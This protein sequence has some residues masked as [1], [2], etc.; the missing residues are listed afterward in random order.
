MS[1][2]IEVHTAAMPML[3]GGPAF[4]F[5]SLQGSEGLGQLFGYT[6][7][8]QTPDAPQLTAS[9]TANLPI[10]NLVGKEISIVIE[11]EGKGFM[12]GLGAGTRE[13]NGL[14]T[15]GRFI[16]NE[17][18]RG[19]Y[20][21]TV[22]PW[23]VL[24]TRT[25]DYK[26]FQNQTPLAIVQQVLADYSYL[27]ETRV[28][29]SY[30]ER[31]FQVQ[32]GE[33]DF[34]F[35]SR[36]MQE[37]G[38]YYYFEHRGGV[39][40]LILVDDAGT[41][42]P[43]PSAAYQTINFYGERA[44]LDEE[45][46]NHFLSSEGLQSGQWVTDDF[47][48]TKPRA[49]LQSLVKMPRHTG[50]NQQELYRW[51]GDYVDPD[52]GRALARTRMEEAGAPGSRASGSGNLR[53]I[54]PGC[55]FKLQKYPQDKANI[56]YLVIAA[57]LS[58][59]ESSHASG[60]VGYQCHT[61]F[62]LQPAANIYRS[63]QTVPKPLTTGPQTA[64]VTGPPGQEI[65][66]N[67]YGQIKVSFHWNRYCTKD[68]N[69]SCWIRVSNP[70]AGSNFG[71]IAI[72]RI[73]QEV[74]V[75]FEN[76]DPDRPIITGRVYNALNMPP[77]DLPGN[78][79]Q[80]GILTRS[81]LD[82][83]PGAG[84]KDG[85]GDAN[86]LRFEDKKGQEQLWLHAQK[87]QL[88]EVEHDEDKWVGNDR[89]K[90]I[91][92]DETNQIKR[93][94]TE[95]V[96]RNEKITVHGWRMEEVDGDET[97][98]IHSNRTERVDHHEKISIGDN[99][100]EEV[101]KDENIQVGKNRS[102]KVGSSHKIKVG[103]SQ[104]ETIG[105]M[106]TQTVGLMRMDN[107]GIA[108]NLNVGAAW[109]SNVGLT[110]L[111]NIGQNWT[112]S[113]GSTYQITAK[114]KY[115]CEVGAASV[116]MTADGDIDIQG[117][118]IRINGQELVEIIGGASFGT[119]TAESIVHG[120]MGGWIEHA[121][122]HASVGPAAK[123]GDAD[124]EEPPEEECQECKNAAAAASGGSISYARGTERITHTDFVVQAP[125]PIRWARRYHSALAAYDRGEL[126]AR[127][128][129][130]YTSRLTPLDPQ[131]DAVAAIQVR[132]HAS[133]GRSHAYPL[134]AVGRN[135]TD[136]IENLVLQR[137]SL[138]ELVID[139]GPD[140]Q[141][142]YEAAGKGWRLVRQQTPQGQRIE[143]RYAPPHPSDPSL[144]RAH[145]V[146]P[147]RADANPWGSVPA[148][149]IAFERLCDV[150]SYQGDSVMAHVRLIWDGEGNA[151]GHAG[152]VTDVV[153]VR[154]G[155]VVRELAA[156]RYDAAGDLVEALDENALVSLAPREQAW[157]YQYQDHLLTRYTDRTQ[158]GLNLQWN[159][160]ASDAR[161]I[162]EWADDGSFETRITWDAVTGAATV[163][164]ALGHMRIFHFDRHGYTLRIEHPGGGQE[165]LQ[166]D[167][168]RNVIAHHKRDGS[169]EHLRYETDASGRSRL[170]QTI[171]ADGSTIGYQ[172]NAQR[173][174]ASI[175][176]PS[177]HV[178]RRSYNAAG[179]LASQTDPLGRTTSYSYD[180]Q[181][182]LIDI[183]DP[184]N[185]AKR[186]GYTEHGQIASFTDCSGKT[187]T[188]AYDAQG[189]QIAQTNAAGVTTRYGYN[190]SQLATM[191]TPDGGSSQ[192]Q[193]DAE[194]RL[195]SHTDPLGRK[196]VYHYGHAGLIASRTQTMGDGK[197]LTLHYQWDKLGRLVQLTN[198]NGAVYQ[199]AY[200]AQARLVEERDF[201]GQV[202]RYQ[203][204]AP[205][206]AHG[207]TVTQHTADLLT[208]FEYDPL[209]RLLRRE[210]EQ[211]ERIAGSGNPWQPVAG[212]KQTESFQY[213]AAGRMTAA[214][215]DAS[216]L[217]WFYDPVGNLVRE[218]HH[219]SFTDQ[220]VDSVWE[221]TYDVLDNR[222][223]TTRPDGYQMQ[224][225]TYGSGHVHGLMLDGQEL[226]GFERDEL[227][228]EK[229][230][231]QGNGLTQSSA[232]DAAGRLQYQSLRAGKEQDE[233][234]TTVVSSTTAAS[235]LHIQRAYQYDAA[236]QLEVIE[237]SRRGTL[238]YR[239]D[240]AS[241]LIE[242][243]SSLG[244]ELFAF[245]PAGNL[246]TST[247]KTTSDT[248]AK[249]I[250][251]ETYP[252]QTNTQSQ[253]PAPALL[254]NLLR[255]SGHTAFVH[256]RRGNV[257]QIDDQASGKR[258]SLVWDGFNR[259][260]SFSRD[261]DIQVHY[262][263]D[264]LGRRIGKH[265]Q[266]IVYT[267]S[268][269]G[270]GW[271]AAELAK[272]AA[273]RGLGTTLYG[274]E[275]DTLAYERNV[276]GLIHYVNEPN[277]FVPMLRISQKHGKNQKKEIHWFQC[278]HL[279]TPM[280]LTNENGK[281]AWKA[282]YKAF[283]EATPISQD[284]KTNND[285]R[286]QGQYWDEESELHYN[287][288]R[289]YD[290]K[291]GRYITKDPI[292]L[293]DGNNKFGYVKSDPLSG[294]DPLGLI[295]YN[296]PAPKTVPVDGQTSDNLSCLETCLMGASSN[297]NLDLL[298]TGGAETTGHSKASHH[299]KGEAVDIS[300]S[301][302]V[303]KN[304]MGYCAAACGFNAGQCEIFPSNKNRNHWHLQLEPG[305]GV[306][307]I[308]SPPNYEIPVKIIEK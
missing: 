47:D 202:T 283:G 177:G 107:V 170:V 142:V 65:Y 116:Q 269:N 96:D 118:N 85:P 263:Y 233:T 166:R 209:G 254:D 198:E 224:W 42:Q 11:L 185:H 6:V 12:A 131:Q 211:Y 111:D 119:W 19:I 35:I 181:N 259:L 297:L 127:W 294:V 68:Q 169:V 165:R 235:H 163:T 304:D 106:S 286:F 21:V 34:D 158:R 160:T 133:D 230:R 296:K 301:N 114:E 206:Q 84:M 285:I 240:P 270:P 213:D 186:L 132:L 73:G 299:S 203:H 129:T 113:V 24:A 256:D 146:I 174:M 197:A 216:R 287:L 124:E 41:H 154:D 252:T 23:L 128:I 67:E 112:Q 89:R 200:D 31:V 192:L 257:T 248:S 153:E 212:S 182:R 187:T 22:E 57:S 277:S 75:D 103:K 184:A 123:G 2:A 183:V 33:T 279:G 267:N 26:I 94:R 149:P 147:E 102:L 251:A 134:P 298:V 100:D 56:D 273:E 162:R 40:K 152:L 126:G 145:Q 246:L 38:I 172:W 305:N 180:A 130:A 17:N 191:T 143:L 236:G 52:E 284:G 218:H 81:S 175:T 77:W 261:G 82:G 141:E 293:I 148:T 64:I 53:A 39:H 307:P 249:G 199:F 289:Y 80:S 27:T 204:T 229:L 190:G 264:P 20:E 151:S 104:T 208:R 195:L 44:K 258:Q 46:C 157:H 244:T 4:E 25:S 167:G 10:K 5:K 13:I 308:G 144:P 300:T 78:M 268:R 63:P 83:A 30:P 303:N 74:I 189:K 48:F 9:V 201:D 173:R 138:T 290:P 93:D 262:Y 205:A 214:S 101:G 105:L 91:D 176:D 125:L 121:A 59:H 1:R 275:G 54:V 231:I 66:T 265:S 16:R 86:A 140:W 242:A 281:L 51:P 58:L 234:S 207:R 239:Y 168:D 196:T 237:D 8:L 232:Y 69:S 61:Q 274:W 241:R 278:D 43:F 223:A 226:V 306:P 136:P 217:Q 29:Q 302:P 135:H 292:G 220:A 247:L 32:Y 171:R 95:T 188:W 228:R 219:Y 70:W 291:Q 98:T 76:G 92:R 288:H 72:P 110:R 87:D 99:R 139:Y 221:H 194:G 117:K 150:I 250:G 215:N 15:S 137:T 60:Q 225:L 88:T 164:D 245:D 71:A 97:I 90:T 62:Q 266:A 3:L 18:R 109:M 36:L 260:R 37:F 227:H 156:Y 243:S 159:G 155:E 28:C 253:T 115:L 271:Q 7:E 50:H 282:E 272:L 120:T 280:E 193:H 161:A 210:A 45:Y 276:N 49:R 238:S 122:S 79:T 108:Y 179:Q 295:R 14:V 55:M 222:V 255:H 178:W